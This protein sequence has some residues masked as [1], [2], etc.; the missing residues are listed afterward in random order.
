MAGRVAE[1]AIVRYG[2]SINSAMMNAPAPIMG[3]MIWP[4]VEATAST[5]AAKGG[6]KPRRF[7]I[8]MV[9]APVVT[10]FAEALPEMVP[11]MALAT[12]ATLAGPPCNRPAGRLA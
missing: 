4:P 7:I 10:T 9:K 11:H 5:A 8:G 2:V 3:G 1:R 6:R 12:V